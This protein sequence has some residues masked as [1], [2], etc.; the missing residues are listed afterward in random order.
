MPPIKPL[1]PVET[2]LPGHKF[3]S[4]MD[5][6]HVNR[7]RSSYGSCPLT[8]RPTYTAIV[9]QS[10]TQRQRARIAS[11]CAVFGLL[12]AVQ[13]CTHMAVE[14]CTPGALI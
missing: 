7:C 12:A 13:N 4:K 6:S 1:F 9:G 5:R 10:R 11:A 8:Q 2:R 3:E 14:N